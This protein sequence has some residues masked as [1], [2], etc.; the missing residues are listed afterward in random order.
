ML[1]KDQEDVLFECDQCQGT[2]SPNSPLLID[3]G[4]HYC[5]PNCAYIA[6]HRICPTCTLSFI[7]EFIGYQTLFAHTW[8][9]SKECCRKGEEV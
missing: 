5:S 8:Y 2:I 9:C 7:K 1:I 3:N 6:T 4:K